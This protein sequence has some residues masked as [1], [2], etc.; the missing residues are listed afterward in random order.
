LFARRF[1]RHAPRR[2]AV[3]KPLKLIIDNYPEDQQEDCF[4][5]NHPQKPEWGKR[6]IPFSKVLY[7]ERDDFMEVPPKAISVYRPV[8]KC[9]CAMLLSSNACKWIKMRKVTSK[10]FIAP[11]IPIPKA[12]L[13]ARI[14]AKSKAISIGYPPNMHNRQRYAV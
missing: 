14:A 12:E 1:E 7:I 8:R 11:M 6:T 4:A 2:V 9:D 10:R 13:P 5:P 3:L